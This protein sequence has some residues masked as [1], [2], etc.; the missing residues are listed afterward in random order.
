MFQ[1]YGDRVGFL[2]VY[3][4]EAHAADEWQLDVNITDG[5]VFE[6]PTTFSARQGAARQCSGELGL[7][8][9]GVIDGLDNAVDEAYAAWPE[10]LFV[11]GVDDR[12]AYAGQQGPFGFKPEELA[13]WLRTNVGPPT[14]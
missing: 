11:I 7:S 13:T 10:R 3:I 12:I 14:P 8:M 4:Q 6:Q 9:P 5:V 2:F 1:Q